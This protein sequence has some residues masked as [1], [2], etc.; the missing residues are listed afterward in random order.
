MIS[1][2]GPFSPK[3]K[4]RMRA[5]GKRLLSS[6]S[7]RLLIAG[8]CLTAL[9]APAFAAS[10]ITAKL[11]P[12]SI[13]LGESAQLTV[14]VNG[15]APITVSD[16]DGLEIAPIGQQTSMQ[17]INGTVTSKVAQFFRITPNRT[18]DF[19]IPAIGGNGQAV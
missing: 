12:Q 3:E 19:I 1:K 4:V 18:G 17:M 14:T 10:Q 5:L 11:E 13:V 6:F 2:R 15:P 16:V 8:L 9:V 7:K